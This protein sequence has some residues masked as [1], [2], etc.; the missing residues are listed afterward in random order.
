MS[1]I[2]IHVEQAV[3]PIR[4]SRHRK[5]MMREELLAHLEGIYQEELQR[6][7]D[8]SEATRA[9]IKR[10]GPADEISQRLQ[11]SV[12]WHSWGIWCF[13]QCIGRGTLAHVQRWA[14]RWVLCLLFLAIL[15]WLAVGIAIGKWELSE[16]AMLWGAFAAYGVVTTWAWLRYAATTAEILGEGGRGRDKRWMLQVV[17]RGAVCWGLTMTLPLLFW[18]GYGCGPHIQAVWMG[19]DGKLAL[20]AGASAM[21]V[22]MVGIALRSKEMAEHLRVERQN[23]AREDEWL[24]LELD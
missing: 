22:L 20:V 2:K 18:S 9:A 8:A 4:A 24:R 12:P 23:D 21:T 14:M 5:L 15:P 11:L 16:A 19:N 17:T 10:F 6:L 7:G 1:A 3:R 13:F